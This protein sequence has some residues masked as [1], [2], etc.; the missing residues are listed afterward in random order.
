MPKRNG[1]AGRRTLRQAGKVWREHGALDYVA[2]MADDA[3][4]GKHTSF[5]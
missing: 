3:K 5:P 1:A 2:G 4:R